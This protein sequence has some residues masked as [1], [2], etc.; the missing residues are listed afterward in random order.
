MDPEERD[1]DDF[2][3]IVALVIGLI[4]AF[5]VRDARS[6]DD[7]DLLRHRVSVALALES[8]ADTVTPPVPP[9]ISRPVEKPQ[10]AKLPEVFVYYAPFPCA[11]C[12]AQ[13]AALAAWKNPTLRIVE[14]TPLE[15]MDAFPQT[16]WRHGDKTYSLIGWEG[17]DK[18]LKQY[19]ATKRAA[20]GTVDSPGYQKPAAVS[21]PY[22]WVYRGRSGWTWPGDLREHLAR[23]HSI[24]V[25]GKT[26]EQLEALHDALHEGR[27]VKLRR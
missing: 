12:D 2:A 6:A 4:L 22:R 10:P 18:F 7:L 20:A 19:D 25:E 26:F 11:P 13:R 8:L 27:N 3:L 24:N 14:K 9:A 16:W 1:G 23:T 5:T 15:S 17:L 21:I